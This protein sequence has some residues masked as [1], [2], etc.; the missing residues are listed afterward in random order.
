MITLFDK[1]TSK[2]LYVLENNGG[3]KDLNGL[4][5]T[6]IGDGILKDI[7]GRIYYVD[8]D[9]I[10][11]GV[12]KTL[13][14]TFT[15]I[16]NTPVANPS[17][18]ANWNSF[19]DLPTNGNVFKSVS[20]IGNEVTL[21]GGSDIILKSELFAENINITSIIDEGCILSGSTFVFRNATSLT[22][23]SLSGL[24]TAGNSCFQ[25]C[26][27]LSSVTLPVLTSAGISCFQS[28]TSLTTISLPSLITAGNSCFQGCTSLTTVSLSGLTTTGN[29]CFQGCTSLTT[30]LL[31]SCQNLG[32]TTGDNN[33]FFGIINNNIT[34]TVPPALMTINGGNPDG[35]IDYLQVNNIVNGVN[36]A[37]YGVEWDTTL[38]TTALTR[39]GKMSLHNATTGLPVQS[40]MRRCLLL[41]NG[42]VNYY[43]NP[44]NS[45]Q[46]ADGSPANLTGA[47]GQ[48]MVEIPQHYRKFEFSGNIQRVL[49]SERPFDGA[50]LVPLQYISAFE[51]AVQRST[52]KLSSV[53]NTTTDYRGGNN[54][55]AWDA[56]ANSLLGKP[57]TSISRINFTTFASNR[58]AKWFQ[59]LYETYKTVVWL[60]MIEYAQ[61]NS[62]TPFNNTLTVEGY[63]QG[64]LGEGVTNINNTTWNTFN[65]QNPFLNCGAGAMNNFTSSTSITHPT[66]GI[67]QIPVYRGIEHPFGHIWKWAEGINV[68]ALVSSIE[69]Y[70][71][72]AYTFSS[73]NYTGY[74][75]Q[76]NLAIATDYIRN[77]LTGTASGQV[78]I[79][80]TTVGSGASSTTF[81]SD[82][83]FQSRPG[84]GESL[85]AVFFGGFA[86]N[87]VAAGLLYSSVGNVPASTDTRLGA[88]LCFIPNA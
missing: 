7:N 34:L 51:A 29:S 79:M 62:Q 11:P 1:I 86:Y 75:L 70:T 41:D 38:G 4:P 58:G 64:G 73:T 37:I 65:G 13:K 35:D 84:S 25:G 60:Y 10:T 23:V 32:S 67:T 27:L 19:F 52:N 56:A 14:L 3:L 39:V 66:L 26:T 69:M 87:G 46:K 88:R 22:T 85:R 43:L 48:V 76:G 8:K 21:T 50:H 68:R 33:V 2:I 6:I 31:P 83:Y 57:A 9:K 71:A 28:C 45:N 80:P 49:I 18:V 16:N 36:V 44:N 40:K 72:N 17:S 47:D 82:Q 20:I 74:S 54:T 77:L 30:I 53:I 24:I 63:R 42:T 12:Q 5:Y 15:N 81:W 61:R 59:M 78:E 55:S